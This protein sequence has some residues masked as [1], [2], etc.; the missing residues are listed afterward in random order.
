VLSRGLEIVDELYV[1]RWLL[2]DVFGQD[3]AREWVCVN[4]VITYCYDWVQIRKI[5]L[6]GDRKL[7]HM[8]VRRKRQW[9]MTKTK[10]RPT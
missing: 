3:S 1:I 7:S 2:G 6:L 5:Y 10:R 9:L 8:M 4:D